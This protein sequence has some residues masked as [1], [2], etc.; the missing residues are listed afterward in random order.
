MNHTKVMINSRTHVI[1]MFAINYVQVKVY[2]KNRMIGELFYC[3]LEHFTIDVIYN[4]QFSKLYDRYPL[5]RK[6]SN[7]EKSLL[8]L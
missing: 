7:R 5:L 2:K 3:D 8:E 4:G 1:L 6:Y